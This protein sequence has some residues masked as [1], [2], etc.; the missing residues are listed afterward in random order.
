M[1]FKEFMRKTGSVIK[2]F[3]AWLKPHLIRFHKWRKRIWK[4]YQI[5]KIIL[6]LAMVAVLVTSIYLFTLAKAANVKALKEG[7]QQST[8]IY[9]KNNDEAGKLFGQKGTFVELDQISPYIQDA[10]VSTEDRNFYKHNGY[11]I[12]G[13]FRAVI[14]RVTMGRMLE[15]EVQLRS[16]WQKMLI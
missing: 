2:R 6:L 8:V 3:W 11:D 1:D 15:A 14:G 13:I 7:L 16:S 4:K 10:V 12:K 5:N 9:D